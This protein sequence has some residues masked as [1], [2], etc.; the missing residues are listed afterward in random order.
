M[1][2]ASQSKIT[3]YFSLAKLGIIAG[4][5]ITAAGGFSL[6]A[7]GAVNLPLFAATLLGLALI[8]GSACVLNNYIDRRADAKMPRTKNRPLANGAIP[9]RHA[10]IY[11]CILGLL[12]VV[13]LF[14]FTPLLSLTVAVLGFAIYV[15]FYSY[16]KYHTM[17]ATL[18]GTLAG[19]TAP[20]VGY[21]SA[22]KTFELGTLIFFFLM[23]FW[24]M[25]HFYAI[26]IFREKEYA[27]ASIPVFPIK[28]GIQKTKIHILFYILAFTATGTLFTFAGY[29]NN[30]F[31]LAVCF[32][33]VSWFVYGLKGLK[34][35]NDLLWARKMFF[36][37]LMV[38][39]GICASIPFSF[40][41]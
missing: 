40:P 23:V 28:K 39:I 4:N 37:S 14:L 9:I 29:L 19:A 21:C 41:H 3:I 8:I 27:A 10:L 30:L 34:A 15:V 25:A 32:F 35:D 1:A 2:T 26:A 36:F 12:G 7:R 5:M 24:Q 13:C 17:H 38:I 20:L 11:S 16:L 22:A 31:L 33:G 6:G 18:I